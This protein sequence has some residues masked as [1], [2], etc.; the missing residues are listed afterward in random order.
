MFFEAGNRISGFSSSGAKQRTEF[1]S[2][3]V[4]GLFNRCTWQ[5]PAHLLH[6]P[7]VHFQSW[8]GKGFSFHSHAPRIDR[9][10]QMKE[11]KQREQEFRQALGKARDA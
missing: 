7:A 9:L 4:S 5:K 1:V 8:S 2:F 6:L 11:T 10:F 3:H